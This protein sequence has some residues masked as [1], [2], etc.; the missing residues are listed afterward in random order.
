MAV[1][2][3]RQGFKEVGQVG[4]RPVTSMPDLP[5]GVGIAQIGSSHALVLPGETRKDR[6]GRPLVTRH[7][8]LA[9]D[10]HRGKKCVALCLGARKVVGGIPTSEPCHAPHV[11]CTSDTADAARALSTLIGEHHV[12]SVLQREHEQ[13]VVVLLSLDAKDPDA[14]AA[15]VREYEERVSALA[16]AG[17][18]YEG[19]KIVKA[20]DYT[21]RAHLI[22]MWGGEPKAPEVEIVGLLSTVFRDELQS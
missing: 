18:K 16:E 19:K 9:L 17:A 5:G 1:D 12:E 3:N 4:L 7:T 13:H 6:H 15:A 2:L 11:P 22:A 14:H 10:Q 8:V 21:A 20:P